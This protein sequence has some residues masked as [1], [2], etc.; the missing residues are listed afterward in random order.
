MGCA[1]GDVWKASRPSTGGVSLE[2]SKQ[3]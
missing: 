3:G 2:A 1:L